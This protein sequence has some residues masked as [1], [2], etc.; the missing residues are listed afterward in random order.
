[1]KTNH[2]LFA[3]CI[4]A[5]SAVNAAAVEPNGIGGDE[6][7]QP[8]EF[9]GYCLADWTGAVSC[10]E[11]SREPWQGPPPPPSIAQILTG[12]PQAV[13]K[14]D[15]RHVCGAILV[16]PDWVLTA[17][18]CLPKRLVKGGLAVRFG[19]A[20]RPATRGAPAGVIRPIMKV[21]RHPNY[22]R[23]DIALV[24][25]AEDPAVHVANPLM[26]PGDFG[27]LVF[28]RGPAVKFPAPGE[29]DIP[30]T[31]V[32]VASGSFNGNSVLFR[33]NRK[34]GGPAEIS[35]TPLFQAMAPLCNS[36]I[37]RSDAKFDDDIFCAL[38]HER[39]VCPV[40]SGAPVMGGPDNQL[41][42]VAITTWDKDRCAKDGEP[43]RFTLTGPI[44]PWIRGV[45]KESYDKRIRESVSQ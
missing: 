30:F 6:I 39:P 11:G 4:L 45:L 14:P 5:L 34:G 44:R 18:H 37:E 19:F 24:Q 29:P 41:L 35:A 13:G 12:D 8:Q 32:S 38:S 20:G 9:P 43:G 31:D 33:W 40:D 17:A 3:I 21:V 28:P 10:F 2:P 16:A 22:R 7:N 26:S 15:W 25:F 36:Q 1:M 23:T 27:D 42:V